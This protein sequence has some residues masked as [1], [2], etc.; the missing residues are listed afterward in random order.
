M[1]HRTYKGRNAIHLAEFTP[2]WLN[3]P[4][5]P[6]NTRKRTRLAAAL[7]FLAGCLLLMIDGLAMVHFCNT[8]TESFIFA[9]LT[10]P[11]GFF[12]ILAATEARK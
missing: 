4:D 1:P 2:A 9:A 10:A 6:E 12:I 11:T 7:W 5:I 8:V 3:N